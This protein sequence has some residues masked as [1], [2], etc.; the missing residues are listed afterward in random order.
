M[1]HRWGS[2]LLSFV[3]AAG[4]TACTVTAQPVYDT[5]LEPPPPQYEQVVVQPGNVW[6]EGR[7]EYVGGGWKWRPG[8]YEAERPGYAYRGG[9]WQRQGNRW[10]YT[11]GRW[12]QSTARPNDVIIRDHRRDAPPE[13]IQ[14]NQPPPGTIVVPSRDPH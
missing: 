9:G 11:E 13:P 6:V 12:E 14:P 4:L 7:W 5:D 2:G 10:H 8:H 1:R 3:F